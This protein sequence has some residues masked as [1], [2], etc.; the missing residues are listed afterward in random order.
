M[1]RWYLTGLVALSAVS[2][3]AEDRLSIRVSPA[4]SYAP[5][6][7]I[8]RTAVAA[9]PENRTIEIVAESDDFYRSSEVDVDG[10]RAPRI[11]QFE[12]RSLPSGY[13]SVR[14]ILK[15]PG[16]KER[17][18]SQATVRVIDSGGSIR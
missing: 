17:A 16:G 13:Y 18:T 8:V 6:N 15:G 7:L 10:D 14:A 4:V 3:S 2:L 11:T 9:S 5:A 12:F 1:A